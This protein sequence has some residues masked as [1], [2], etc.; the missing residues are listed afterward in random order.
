MSRENKILFPAILSGYNPKVD[1][2]FTIRFSTN[3]LRSDEKQIIDAMFQKVCV[4]MVKSEGIN[5]V[6]FESDEIEAFDSVDMDLVDNKKTPSQR[7]RDV[8]YRLWEQEGKESEWKEFYKTKIEIL[9]NHY[10]GKL[11]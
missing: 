10:K 11:L 4:V 3:V 5:D 8:L 6:K 2:S 9:I 1:G 7:L